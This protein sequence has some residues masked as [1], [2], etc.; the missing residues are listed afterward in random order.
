MYSLKNI[1]KQYA[2][3]F[4][5]W[6]GALLALAFAPMVMG[7]FTYEESFRYST[8]P[9]WNFG[10][11]SGAFTPTL[12]GGGI[13]PNGD[14]WLRMTTASNNQSTYAYFDN[15]IPSADNDITVSFDYTVW[16]GT[17]ADG[18][19]VFLYDAATTFDPGAFGGSLGYANIIGSGG[20]VD[21]LDGGWVGVGLDTYGNYSNPNEGRNG[22]VGFRPDEV[23]VRG[24]GSG[25]TGY[26]YVAGTGGINIPGDGTPGSAGDPIPSLGVSLQF[27][28]RPSGGSPY[29]YY[30][31][32]V[33]ISKDNFVTARIDT[34]ASDGIGDYT[35]L[36]TTDMSGMTRPSLSRIG[37]TA[38]T[39]GATNYHEI[40]N[41][42]IETS[43][44]PVGTN[45]WDDDSG[46]GLWGTTVNW[47]GDIVPPSNSDI[48]F[49]DDYG[50]GAESVNVQANRTV[51]SLNFDNPYAYTLNNRR[52]DFEAITGS[53]G[54]NVSEAN[55]VPG[56]PIDH[57]INSTV[58]FQDDLTITNTASNATL[59]FGGVVNGRNSGDI[60]IKGGG[61]VR[62]DGTIR[63]VPVINIEDGT[64]SLGASHRIN[65]NVDIELSGGTFDTGGFSERVD[66]LTLSASS[67][68]D[69]GSGSSTLLFSDSSAET[70]DS[71]AILS[72]TNWSGS[73]S[74]G[75]TDVIRFGNNTSALTTTQLNQIRFV[76]PVGF[77]PGIYNAIILSN[78]EI[79]PVVPEPSTIIFGGLLVAVGLCDLYRRYRRK[80][81]VAG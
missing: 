78:G 5:R 40:R 74:G 49:A 43:A 39:G 57:T 22:G 69:L 35:T 37:F 20:P 19:T 25:Q 44:Q 50:T 60:I 42:T 59:V 80:R 18:L 21:G 71:S 54:I 7:Q 81:G 67:T 62:V 73:T 45:F 75:G 26:E 70:W 65:N 16:G 36:F 52:I 11:D 15:T 6:S 56:S 76:N 61:D 46:N 1:S 32:Q 14:G 3:S 2:T 8:A 79:V 9:G 68:I 64:L 33:E 55:G 13:D 28:S 24:P 63:R 29:N 17:G 12:T 31:I 51:R 77:N 23:A 10:F 47:V 48:F 41:L 30:G 4:I 38:S 27:P 53:I 58:R 72:I 34:D 66:T